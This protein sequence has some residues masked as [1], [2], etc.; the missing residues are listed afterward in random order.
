MKN[1]FALFL[2]FLSFPSLFAQKMLSKNSYVHIYSYT[3]IED[4]EASLNDGMAILN[5]ETKEIAYIL[6]IQSLTFKNALMQEHFNENYMESEK[7]P[8]A[9]LKG[10]LSGNV[11]FSK[12][13]KYLLTVKGKLKMHGVDQGI[14]VPIELNIIEDLSMVLKTDFFVKCEDFG[15][16]IPKLM[17]TRIAQDIKVSVESKFLNQ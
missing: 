16:K 5:I 9:T 1:T 11:N 6:N 4:I 2:F 12:P 7:F 8:K 17:F 15:I 10:S 14:S 13:G 3:P